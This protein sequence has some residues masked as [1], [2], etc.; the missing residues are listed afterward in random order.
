MSAFRRLGDQGSA[1]IKG[2]FS[3]DPS[4]HHSLLDGGGSAPYHAL[5][6]VLITR[7]QSSD[8]CLAP[9]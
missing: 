3:P 7:N 9:Y 1:C 6:R 4:G 5:L 8:T 2:S